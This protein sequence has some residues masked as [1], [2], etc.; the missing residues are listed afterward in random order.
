MSAASHPQSFI[1]KIWIEEGRDGAG[2]ASW[3]GH[4]THVPT[5][6][7]QYLQSV[8]EIGPFIVSHLQR[9]GVT[10]GRRRH[11]MEWCKRLRSA[12]RSALVAWLSLQLWDVSRRQTILA[13]N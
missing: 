7:R 6:E 8:D 1:I 13:A 10:L 4:I 3:R 12:F 11:L 2:Q 5:G 9:M